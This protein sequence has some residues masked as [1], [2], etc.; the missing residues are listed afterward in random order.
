MSQLRRLVPSLHAWYVAVR[1]DLP[2]RR[3][4][5]PYA[6]WV[7]EVML[8]QTR[9]ATVIPYYERWMAAFPTVRALAAAEESRVLK[10]WE[11][12][13]YYTRARNLHR[14][15]QT[16][17]ER[18]GGEIPRT[19]DEFRSLPGVGPYSAAAVLS[20]AFGVPLAVVD[21]TVRRVLSRLAALG[22]ARTGSANLRLVDALAQELLAAEA[23]SV[24]NQ[25]M[26]ELGAT[27]CSPRSPTCRPC[28][29]LSACRAAALG[30][31]GAYPTRPARRPVPHVQVAIG[32][33]FR[34]EREL[35]ID[36]RPYGGL[37]GGLWE[38]PGGK[39]EGGES[40]EDALR[41]ELREE[42]GMEVDVTGSLSPVDHVYT[43]LKVTLHPR[44]C[45]LVSLEPRLG[46]GRPFRWIE[47]REL[48]DYAMPRANRRVIEELLGRVTT[49]TTG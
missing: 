28:P 47:L 21:G 4:S 12:L 5:D 18:F 10:L 34:N 29:F 16:V 2:W 25:A 15:A 33:V 36:R 22:G 19:P 41:R 49:P 13:G 46:E 1:R 42:F 38:F 31:P 11:G 27:L 7:S 39:V 37:L 45:R 3:T 9:V 30:N 48:H 40:V 17:V 24:H 8:Q 26:M 32:V 43:H 20:I 44:L 23:P 35:F 6:V 14:A